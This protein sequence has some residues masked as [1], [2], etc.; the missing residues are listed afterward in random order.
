MEYELRRDTRGKWERRGQGGV[1]Y[2]W[3]LWPSYRSWR[4]RRRDEQVGIVVVDVG[5]VGDGVILLDKV[6]DSRVG[7]G[8]WKVW[9]LGRHGRLTSS[10]VQQRTFCFG[11]R[12][13]HGEG[14]W[15]RIED[16]FYRRPIELICSP[17]TINRNA[18]DGMLAYLGSSFLDDSCP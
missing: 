6:F 18:H 16:G 13:R 1:N 15:R 11:K 5:V 10:E 2:A 17:P 12:L 7:D 4:T 8:V 14:F 9:E 3:C